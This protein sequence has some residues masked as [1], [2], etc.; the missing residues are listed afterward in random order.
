MVSIRQSS[1]SDVLPDFRNLAVIA[2]ILLAVNAAAD[3]LKSQAR[4]AL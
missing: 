1:Y 2:R 3:W 4:E